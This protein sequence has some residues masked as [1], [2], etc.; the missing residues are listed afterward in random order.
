[1]CSPRGCG[2]QLRWR[3]SVNKVFGNRF[4]SAEV[5]DQYLAASTDTYIHTQYWS[6]TPH[7]S[8]G[9]PTTIPPGEELLDKYRPLTTSDDFEKLSPEDRINAI[10]SIKAPHDPRLM[11]QFM[12]EDVKL[13]KFTKLSDKTSAATFRFRVTRFYCNGSGNLH[14]GAQALFFDMLTSLA[15]QAIGTRDFWINGG[16]SRNLEVTFLRPAPEGIDV[17]CEVE[18]MSTGK[19]LSFHRGVMK[20]VSDGA[21]ISVAK[22]DKSFVATKPGWK[23]AKM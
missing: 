18:V 6:N 3:E 8:C 10:L 16:V 20:R 1:M 14:G 13:V 23:T 19:T 12:E 17:L 7:P 11:S 2:W 5:K 21:L 9:Y 15:V 22:H 4:N